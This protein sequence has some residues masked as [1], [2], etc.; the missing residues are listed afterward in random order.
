M[1]IFNRQCSISSETPEWSYADQEQWKTYQNYYL[2]TR[3]PFNIKENKTINGKNKLKIHYSKEVQGTYKSVHETPAFVVLNTDESNYV[4]YDGKKFILDNFH[5][6]NSSEHTIDGKYHSSEMHFVNFH[7]DVEKDMYFFLVVG[8]LL[9]ITKEE[10]G[11][12]IWNVDYKL[13]SEEGSY[14]KIIDLTMF[15]RLTKYSYY[16]FTGTL[17]VP[18][19]RNNIAWNLF[20]PADIDSFKLALNQNDYDNFVY[21][22]QNN[23]ANQLSNYNEARYVKSKN[24]YLVV[25]KINN[26]DKCCC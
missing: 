23:K 19:F 14:D 15:N 17:T 13:L 6:H 12:N 8:C 4:M 24:N 20:K 25:S 9:D 22:F 11:L 18:L 26:D 10:D 16:T 5:I 3:T 1:C 7:Y 21:Y 2:T